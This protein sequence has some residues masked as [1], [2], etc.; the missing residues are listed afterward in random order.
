MEASHSSHPSGQQCPLSSQT[1]AQLEA[2][3][4]RW[5]MAALR[6]VRMQVQVQAQAPLLCDY[7]LPLPVQA[8]AVQPALLCVVELPLLR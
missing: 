2:E 3:P 8:R 6:P 7:L 5:L 4:I 1:A